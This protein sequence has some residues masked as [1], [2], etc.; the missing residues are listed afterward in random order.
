MNTSGRKPVPGMFTMVLHSHLPWLAHHG[1]WPVGEEW[2]YQIW[3]YCYIPMFS[4]LQRLAQQGKTHQ[5][6]LGIT[7]IVAAQLDDPHCL[8][9]M[10]SWLGNW[11]MRAREAIRLSDDSDVAHAGSGTAH[12][13]AAVRQLG[14]YEYQQATACLEIFESQWIHGGSAVI[15]PLVDSGVIELLGGPLAHPFQPLAHQ[16]IRR[17]QLEEGLADTEHRIGTRPTGLWAPECAFAPGMEQ[18]Y[19]ASGITHFMVD[20]PSLR[21]DTSLGRPVHDSNVIAFGR[22]LNVSYRVWSPKS[23]YPGSAAYRDFHT[24]HK[25]T[26]FKPAKVTSKQTDS[27]HKAPYDPHDVQDTLDMHVADFVDTV[28]S[29]LHR[30]H[31]R[32]GQPAHVVA[33]FDTELYGHWWCEGPTWLEQVLAA[34]DEASVTLGTLNDARTSGY[35]GQAYPLGEVS[36]G[37]GKDWRVW[38]GNQVQNFVDLN[39]ELSREVLPYLRSRYLQRPD[40]VTPR[41]VVDDQLVRELILALQSD[42]PFMVSKD[43]AGD[44]ALRRAHEHAHGMRELLAAIQGKPFGSSDVPA[45]PHALAVKLAANWKLA[46]GPFPHLD[47]RRFHTIFTTGNEVNL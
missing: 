29:E 26:G 39:E 34:L 3:G 25:L 46:D 47:A 33:A 22:N 21:G 32:T 19:A 7:P 10:H 15:R 27:Q 23:G 9:S 8:E 5:L 4:M 20:G 40:G 42:W 1:R 17:F 31:H 16:D 24:Y 28:T 12:D 45:D 18:D 38:A 37:S 13:P 36:W 2:L 43:S 30:E 14:V 44:Y 35:V 41:N 6:T 11:Q